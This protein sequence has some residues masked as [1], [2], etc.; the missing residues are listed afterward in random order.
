M[1]GKIAKHYNLEKSK[2]NILVF[3]KKS[4]LVYQT[5]GKEPKETDISKL[6]ANIRLLFK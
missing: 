5:A 2:S 4:V 3:D 6:V 1:K